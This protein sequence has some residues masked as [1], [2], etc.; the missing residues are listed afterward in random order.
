M[1]TQIED[2]TPVD[3]EPRIEVLRVP[4]ELDLASA[5]G[6]AER[7][8]A[9]IASCAWLLL[10]LTG[11][12]FCDARG[13]SAFVRIANHADMAGCRYGLIAPP[14]PI[15]KILP[16]G[17]LDRRMPVYL[18]IDDALEHL[19]PIV[20]TSR[21]EKGKPPNDGST[22]SQRLSPETLPP[23]TGG[24]EPFNRAL[25]RATARRAVPRWG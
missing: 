4:E 24:R 11:L 19:A 7:A 10:D 20:T 23:R 2:Q 16:I 9:A 1:M 8:Y 3:R 13:L 5:D 6:L 21:S 17:G 12:S 15:T 18:T 22:R 14:P 25:A